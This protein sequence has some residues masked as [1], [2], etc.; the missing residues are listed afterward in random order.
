MFFTKS[1]DFF[2]IIW[3]RYVYTAFALDSFK[4]DGTGFVV[5]FCLDGFDIAKWYIVATAR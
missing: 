3:F 4:H 5:N 2:Q 1:F